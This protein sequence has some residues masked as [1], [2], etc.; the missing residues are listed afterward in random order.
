MNPEEF[1]LATRLALHIATIIILMRY[2]QLDAR[3]RMGPSVLA[4]LL[5]STSAYWTIRLLSHWTSLV[6]HEPQI[7]QVI[8]C[9]A[10]FIPVA[11]SKGNVAK[12]YDFLYPLFPWTHSRAKRRR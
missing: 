2:C 10:I 5:L 7:G 12:L 9:L 11:W 1:L 8:I 3:F 6:N 4:G